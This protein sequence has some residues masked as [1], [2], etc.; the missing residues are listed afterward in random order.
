LG[1]GGF[2]G[3]F[4]FFAGSSRASSFLHGGYRRLGRFS[5]MSSDENDELLFDGGTT[6]AWVGRASTPFGQVPSGTLEIY[7]A[8][9]CPQV[10]KKAF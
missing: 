6:G 9:S 2:F 4:F 10:F 1:A 7:T 5:T 3:F 8:R